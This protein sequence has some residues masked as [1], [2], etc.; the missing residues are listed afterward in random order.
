[1]SNIP[2]PGPQEIKAA[3]EVIANARIMR[4]G[5]PFITN[6]LDL[7]P[8]NLREEVLEDTEEALIAAS[9]VRSAGQPISRLREAA[10]EL[11]AALQTLVKAVDGLIIECSNQEASDRLNPVSDRINKAWHSANDAIAKAT[12]PAAGSEEACA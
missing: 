9:A 8:D 4:G 6:V 3:A 10:P 12:L 2:T 5:A 11:L 1:M 7:L